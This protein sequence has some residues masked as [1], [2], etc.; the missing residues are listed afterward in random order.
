MLI[1]P[2]STHRP[3]TLLLLLPIISAW[4]CY[5]P[6][7][8]LPTFRDCRVLINGLDWL[9]R[10]PFENIAKQWGRHLPTN[11]HSEKLPRWY[12]IEGIDPPSTCA[13]VVDVDGTDF[14]HVETFP[15]RNVVVA[16]EIA[17]YE[18]MV[19]KH[20]LGLDFPAEWG[21]IYA[22]VIR[23]PF[24]TRLLQGPDRRRVRR[25]LLPDKTVLVIADGEAKE[26]AMGRNASATE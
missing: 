22:K 13:I 14:W 9:S 15:L 21:H 19:G 2:R 10:Q 8:P 23:S 16:A 5:P 6:P 20:Q 18:C 4:V 7:G 26:G 12:Y 3:L 17:F 1:H 25:V 24:L 11:L